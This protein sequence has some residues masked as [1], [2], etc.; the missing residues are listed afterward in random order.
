MLVDRELENG[1]YDTVLVDDHGATCQAVQHL[2]DHGHRRI[3]F[4]GKDSRFPTMSE[5]H[6][7]YRDCL[8]DAGIR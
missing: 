8:T 3:A 2:V 6:R 4:V 5:R 1:E 7:G